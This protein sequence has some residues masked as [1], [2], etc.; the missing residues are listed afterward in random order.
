M[1]RS[2]VDS[3]VS[4][5]FWAADDNFVG[6]TVCVR[7]GCGGETAALASFDRENLVVRLR[8]VDT[9]SAFTIGVCENHVAKLTVPMGWTL[10]DE[11]SDAPAE[12]TSLPTPRGER[13]D[14]S[15]ESTAP[16]RP[17]SPEGGLLNRAFQGP[18]SDSQHRRR[19][20]WLERSEEQ[21]PPVA[22]DA[23][24]PGDS[25]AA[26]DA[27][28]TDTTPSASASADN[29]ASK[30]TSPS[31]P[32]LVVPARAVR[33]TVSP[34]PTRS[35]LPAPTGNGLSGNAISGHSMGGLPLTQARGF[36]PPR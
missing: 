23:P 12:G 7:A 17:S 2:V 9:D 32:P 33:S 30:P 31:A 11:R 35:T 22:P 4:S 16:R 28:P 24:A 13:V 26:P 1:H 5:L 25:P 10:A 3:E 19:P 14:T 21:P 36:L 34:P 20:S 8:N 18:E 6:V 29:A 15:T 27:S